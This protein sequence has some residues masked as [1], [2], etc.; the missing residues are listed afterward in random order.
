M[1]IQLIRKE[2]TAV[3]DRKIARLDREYTGPAQNRVRREIH[4]LQDLKFRWVS[5]SWL[6]VKK[7]RIA[8]QM[9]EAE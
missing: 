8:A 1:N 2:V 6:E 9:A 7:S 3:C 5:S 4:Y